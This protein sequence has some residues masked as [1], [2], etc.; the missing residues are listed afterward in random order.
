MIF[1]GYGLYILFS[2]P[3]L[4]L[5]LWAQMKVKG[6]MNKYSKIRTYLGL[7]G[8]EVARRILDNNGLGNV[9]IEQTSGFLS[10][11]YDPRGKVLRLSPGVYQSNSV[12]ATG[13]AAHEVGHA[14]QDSAGYAPLQLRSAMVPTVQI[15]SWLGPIVFMVGLF[16]NSA[17]GTTVAWIGLFAFALTAI[18][19]LVTLPVELDA[20][21]RAKE[22]LTDTGMIIGEE[23]KGING[24][25]D[26]AAL[27][28]VAGAA[29]AVTTLLYYFFLLTGR[30][31]D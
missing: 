17:T 12:A 14:L 24:V 10:D 31:R 21:R 13:V 26:A 1:G 22:W 9:Q 20:T 15:G 7:T 25:L 30:S 6:A 2:L 19:A 18:F 28:Y 4:L 29:Q 16:M 23:R 5:G 3:A 11:H 8:A 27:T